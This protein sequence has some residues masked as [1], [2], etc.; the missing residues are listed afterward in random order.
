MSGAAAGPPDPMHEPLLPSAPPIPLPPSVSLWRSSSFRIGV[1]VA[2]VGHLL[3][4][5]PGIVA[6]YSFIRYA[7]PD[8]TLIVGCFTML[9]ELGLFAGCLATGI[10]LLGRN[11]NL[12]LGLIQGWLIGVAAVIVVTALVFLAAVTA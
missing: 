9:L 6:A 1:I 8:S 11:R 7:A 2:V 5:S 4:A 10:G 12:A 3:A